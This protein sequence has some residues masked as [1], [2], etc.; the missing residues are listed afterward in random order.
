MRKV[1][2]ITNT[3]T[4]E[5]L[6]VTNMEFNFVGANYA[7]GHIKGCGFTKLYS[8]ADCYKVVTEEVK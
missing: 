5:Q 3:L 6:N 8:M 7:I 4:N 1:I 2:S